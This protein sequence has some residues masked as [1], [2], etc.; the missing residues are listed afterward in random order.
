MRA[1]ILLSCGLLM[2]AIFVFRG[3]NAILTPGI[4]LN[5]AYV[6]G[7]LVLSGWLMFVGSRELLEK[8]KAERDSKGK[9]ES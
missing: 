8:R 3:A 5:E 2:L 1:H 7:G 9:T 4:G 6:L